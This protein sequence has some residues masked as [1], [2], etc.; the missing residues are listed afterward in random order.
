MVNLNNDVIQSKVF[1]DFLLDGLLKEKI[2]LRPEFF[3]GYP[4]NMF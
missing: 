3:L 1:L 4:R 2:F